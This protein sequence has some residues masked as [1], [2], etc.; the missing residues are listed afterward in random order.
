MRPAPRN[1]SANVRAGVPDADAIAE[2]QL[3]ESRPMRILR[4]FWKLLVAIKDGLVLLLMLL[5]FGALFAALS[6]GGNPR[7]PGTGALVVALDGSL[8][9][10]P[11]D[12]DPF[13]ALARS[14][15]NTAFAT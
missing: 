15:A 9:E 7:T 5:F 6:V 14:R 3:F 4:G 2:R 8:V 1:R 12:A 11:S 10:Q 13:A